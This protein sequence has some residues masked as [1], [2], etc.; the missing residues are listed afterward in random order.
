MHYFKLTADQGDAFAQF[1]HG[2][3]LSRGEGVPIDLKRAVD[4]FKHAAA[5][6]VVDAQF[7]FA[8]HLR[9][10]EGASKN[11]KGAA[12][13]LK[14]VGDQKLQQTSIPTKSVALAATLSIG[15]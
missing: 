8:N 14:L 5:R 6:E 11:F 1:N 9:K 3:Y 10:D 12:H 13:Y 7:N 4:Y 2:N 15:T